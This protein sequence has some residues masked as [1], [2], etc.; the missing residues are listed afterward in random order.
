MSV[1]IKHTYHHLNSDD[2]FVTVQIYESDDSG[3]LSLWVYDPEDTPSMLRYVP[4]SIQ[5][6]KE[7]Y[8]NKFG[9]ELSDSSSN[10]TAAESVDEEFVD[11]NLTNN[12]DP[13]G[14][15]DENSV[16]MFREDQAAILAAAQLAN[17][18]D[19]A[20]RG[21]LHAQL[22]DFSHDPQT[23]ALIIAY[24]GAWATL[25]VQYVQAPSS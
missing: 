6:A 23:G 8:E 13:D 18:L 11:S 17:M 3:K 1:S 10:V 2:E 15:S 22:F 24:G 19:E 4:S 14:P 12:E 16:M 25:T 21:S 7:W 20:I 9:V 5:D